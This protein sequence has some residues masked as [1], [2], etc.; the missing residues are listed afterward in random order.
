MAANFKYFKLDLK[1][2]ANLKGMGCNSADFW[3]MLANSSSDST[4]VSFN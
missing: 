3:S 4:D 2:I 1:L